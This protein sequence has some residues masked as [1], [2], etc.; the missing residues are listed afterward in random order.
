MTNKL[1]FLWNIITDNP[2][3]DV[4]SIN[5]TPYCNQRCR[6]CEIGNQKVR[7]TKPLLTK[8]DVVWVIDQMAEN[9]ISLLS[10]GGG[11]PLLVPWLWDIIRYANEKGIRTEVVT[12]GMKIPDLTREQLDTLMLTSNISISIDTADPKVQDWLRGVDRAFDKQVL[13]MK[14]LHENGISFTVATVLTDFNYYSLPDLMALVGTFGARFVKFQPVWQGS[15]F[16]EVNGVDKSSL[17]VSREHIPKLVASLQEVIR[18][19]KQ[20][21]VKTNAADLLD[22]ISPHLESDGKEPLFKQFVTRYRCHSLHFLITINYYGDI[23]P[24]NYLKPIV[25][26]KERTPL[27]KT[28]NLACSGARQTFKKG[29]YFPECIGCTNSIEMGLICSG[30]RYPISNYN[31][32]PKLFR[33]ATGKLKNAR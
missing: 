3:P 8:E 28:W 16:P 19:E 14:L 10:M 15:N 9:R 23:L 20:L 6:Y 21:S 33:M 4:V 13:G 12:N 2:Q 5:L 18:L 24:C 1:F 27:V 30:I 11:E 7:P 32:L 25:N 22:W 29:W 26:I 31:V 17:Q